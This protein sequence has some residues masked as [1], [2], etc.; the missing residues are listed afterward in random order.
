MRS[1][2]T[3]TT[4]D[5]IHWLPRDRTASVRWCMD[6]PARFGDGR[7][8]A[9]GTR[10][11]GGHAGL[12][13]RESCLRIAGIADETVGLVSPPVP[14]PRRGRGG[15]CPHMVAPSSTVGGHTAVTDLRAD[16]R[17]WV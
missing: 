9:V 6:E 12:V 15:A 8:K 10:H 11:D 1:Q 2:W 3:A 5:V 4:A 16:L 14:S 17:G 13:V 7:H